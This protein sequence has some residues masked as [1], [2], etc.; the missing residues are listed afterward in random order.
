[1]VDPLAHIEFSA[2]TAR[3]TMKDDNPPL[4]SPAL[5]RDKRTIYWTSGVL[6]CFST[7]WSLFKT[8]KY[9][10]SQEDDWEVPFEL[11]TDMVYLGS[12]AQGVV[13]GGSFKG[14][15]VAVK[16]LRDKSEPN[17]NHLR[18]LNHEN[19]V[20]FRGVCTGSQFHCLVMEYCQYGPLFDFIHSGVSFNPKQ[21]V[22]WARDIALGMSYLHT[23][24]IIHRDLKSPNVLIADN[25]VVKV[26]DF[27]TSREWN[28]VSAIMSFTGTVAWMAP[29]VI[30][31][32]PCSE[33]VDVWS[34]GVVLWELL[35][36][37]V[38]YKNLET[39]A[40]MW[41]VGTDTIALPVPST[42]PSSI[43]LLLNQCW[44]RVPRNRPPF[45]II[46]AHLE[47]AGE[48]LCSLDQETFNITQALW[49]QEAHSC[50]ERLYA[51]SDKPV[52]TA[53]RREDLNHARD[54]RYVYEQQLTRANELYM[55]V[56]AVRLQLEQR[57]RIIA[58]KEMAL[59]NCRCGIRK[60]F[61]HFHR[62]T[63]S[64]SDGVKGAM[65]I[66]TEN[67]VRRRKKKH[68]INNSAQLL[69]NDEDKP[70]ETQTAIAASDDC[71]AC[72][73]ND[74]SIQNNNVTT[75]T[76]F[77]DTIVEDNGNIIVKDT[78]CNNEISV[79]D[80]Y[81]PDLAHV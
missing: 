68:G 14:E 39:H 37:E 6:D 43:Q 64:S 35:T 48:D 8:G 2:T 77:K 21:I 81:I 72:V 44:N 59:S 58:E 18:K 10:E 78:G 66:V 50:M 63:S 56:C 73:C 25:L 52:P 12:G 70:N 30:R 9:E 23:H 60:N 41:G 69:V 67:I 36:Q 80:N 42:C 47:M 5:E 3:Y 15:M 65:A 22:R 7:V 32:E 31:H 57:E 75:L 46:A 76:T 16:K 26:S 38:P 27:G 24:K 28:D 4:G 51:K 33:R 29:E 11:I 74:E 34:Y 13:F 1:M 53:Q 20:R 61:K 19:I 79:N 49:R 45:K 54:V 71:V 62:Q 17:I 55:E 40:I